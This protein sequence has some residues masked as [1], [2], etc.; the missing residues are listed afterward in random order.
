MG[1]NLEYNTASLDLVSPTYCPCTCQTDVDEERYPEAYRKS[2]YVK[3]SNLDV[4]KP[5]QIGTSPSLPSSLSLPLL[6][7]R[8][9]PLSPLPLSPPPLSS[10]PSIFFSPLTRHTYNYPIPP[11][12]LPSSSSSGRIL[13]IFMSRPSGKLTLDPE[14]HI[15][16]IMF[17]R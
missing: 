15:R 5:F 12:P 17:Y 13:E 4:P 2:E 6:L 9:P 1:G 14:L 10:S 11:P 7:S 3:G 16:V 8:L